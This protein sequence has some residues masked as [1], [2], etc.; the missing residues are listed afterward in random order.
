MTYRLTYLLTFTYLLTHLLTYLLMNLLTYI[1]TYLLTYL[2]TYLL[3]NLHI[4]RLIYSL[5]GH[6]CNGWYPHGA[7]LFSAH[8][9]DGLSVL[10]LQ[11]LCSYVHTTIRETL[12]VVGGLHK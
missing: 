8:H 2:F 3:M 5:T 6:S 9:Y 1:L 7:Q 4:Y 11:L 12:R 10:M